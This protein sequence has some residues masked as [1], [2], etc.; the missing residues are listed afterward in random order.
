MLYLVPTPIG[1]LQDI[2]LRAL[3]TLRMVDEILAE[4]TRTTGILLKHFGIEAKMRSYHAHNEH[5]ATEGIIRDLRG[6]KEI[7]LVSDAGTP[8]ISDPGFLLVRACRETGIQVVPLP[9]PSAIIPALAASGL[10]CDRFHFE[11]FLPH[12]K[13]RKKRWEFIRVYPYTI[14][15][16]ESPFRLIKTLKEAVEYLEPTRRITLAKE[17]SKLY[18]Q[19]STGTAQEHLE[20]L[21]DETRIK[22]EFVVIIEGAEKNMPFPTDE[23][24]SA[25][26]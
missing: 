12:K 2:T 9:G 25:E 24:E 6:G 20:R 8:G 7:A 18:E 11:G 21:E 5:Q 16:Y 1:N 3:D 23:D 26:S 4:D 19:F 15:L 13:G 17:I 10:P 22:G 14:V